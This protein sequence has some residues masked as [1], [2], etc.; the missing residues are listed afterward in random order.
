[1]RVTPIGKF[2]FVKVTKST[3]V[4]GIVLPEVNQQEEEIVEVLGIGPDVTTITKGQRVLCM[5]GSGIP[6][7]MKDHVLVREQDVVAI[8]KE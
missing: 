2:I 6:T 5:P 4:G 1:M 8:V 7:P 3:S